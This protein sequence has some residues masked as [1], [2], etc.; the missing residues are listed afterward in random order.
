M[1]STGR[2]FAYVLPCRHE[3]ILK[4]G[5]SRDPLDRLQTLHP[6]YFEFFDIDQGLLIETDRV[7]DARSIESFLK[8]QLQEH[9]APAP[10]VIP[11]SAAGHTE[12]VPRRLCRGRGRC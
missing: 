6:R 1:G 10:L 11:R 8:A 3:D 2:A 4:V 9:Q 7:P 12:W 5:F